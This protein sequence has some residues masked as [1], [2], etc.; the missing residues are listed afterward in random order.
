MLTTSHSQETLNGE[1]AEFVWTSFTGH[2]P[3]ELLTLGRQ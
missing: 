1:G 2:D 3:R